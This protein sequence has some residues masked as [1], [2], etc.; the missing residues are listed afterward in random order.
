MS[1][2]TT[3]NEIRDLNNSKARF[4][5]LKSDKLRLQLEYIKREDTGLI[6]SINFLK[7]IDNPNLWKLSV[8]FLKTKAENFLKGKNSEEKLLIAHNIN[9]DFLW[10]MILRE[11]DVE[12]Y[13]LYLPVDIALDLAVKLECSMI[14]DLVCQSPKV[15]KEATNK[16]H[17]VIPKG[18]IEKFELL[19]LC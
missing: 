11:K 16:F 17:Y 10:K 6:T 4:N 2:T 14:L 13:V 7:E 8:V 12:Q 9:M 3:N 15:S 18:L 5:A 1:S 19:F